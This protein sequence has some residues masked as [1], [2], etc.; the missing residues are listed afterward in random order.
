MPWPRGLRAKGRAASGLGA[1]GVCASTAKLLQAR[2][3]DR[4]RVR[5]DEYRNARELRSATRVY[6]V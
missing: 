5:M 2:R 4:T 1:G 3:S 6:E